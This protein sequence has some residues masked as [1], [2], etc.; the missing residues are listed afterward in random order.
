MAKT[1]NIGNFNIGKKIRP[2]IIAEIGVNHEGSL[3]LAKQM[4]LDAK[5][6]GAHCVKFQSYKA[7]KLA[8]KHS[9][10]YWDLSE[11]PTKSQY[12]LFKKYDSFGEND[13]T[14]LSNYASQIDV[15]FMS[16]PFDLNAVDFLDPLVPAFKLASADI[17]NVPLLRKCASKNK[18]LIIST[19]SAT[20][21]EIQFAVD[22]A[23]EA[24]AT[25]IA[26][27]HCVLN[28]P[29]APQN[30]KLNEITRLATT[31][32]DCAIGYSDHVIPDQTLSVLEAAS[33]LGASI[34]EKHF[35]H[36][37][38]LKGNDHYHSMDAKDLRA[39]RDKLDYYQQLAGNSPKDLTIENA[40]RANARRSVVAS[41][42]IEA[43]EK[44][45]EENL[46]TK[47][48]GTGI[49]P[50]HWDELLGKIAIT[51]IE[52]DELLDWRALK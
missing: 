51:D 26:L 15:D 1:F 8:S 47:R 45:S 5:A 35:T 48:P 20:L 32:P 27:L 31:F 22:T 2:Y 13:Y 23:T 43:G 4:M 7:E 24:G 37:K 18:P 49:S 30:A 52:E 3:E 44:L 40:A 17:T 38:S 10:S 36:N 14:E 46:T 42:K 28:Y 33:L 6:S 41:K 39:F 29:T 11:E 25:N 34:L 16:T 9:P 12:E 50:I 19:G 21:A